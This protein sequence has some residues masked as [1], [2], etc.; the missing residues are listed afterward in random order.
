MRAA[1][2]RVVLAAKVDHAAEAEVAEHKSSKPWHR[3][4][5]EIFEEVAAL[6]VLVGLLSTYFYPDD[7]RATAIWSGAA[8][9]VALALRFVPVLSKTRSTQI[10]L[11]VA[12][13]A[14]LALA[15]YEV[16]VKDPHRLQQQQAVLADQWVAWQQSVRAVASVCDGKK[17]P[18]LEACLA[19][20]LP[21]VLAR[22]PQ[23]EGAL[24]QLADAEF[25]GESLLVNSTI[26]PVLLDRLSIDDR[27]IG[28]GESEPVGAT[29][30]AAA[31]VPE[32]LVANLSDS[33]PW[34]WAWE[35]NLGEFKKNQ[36]MLDRKLIDV[37]LTTPP[38]PHADGKTF[39]DYWSWIERDHL[40]NYQV[41]A[42]VRFVPLDPNNIHGEK[43]RPPAPSG[44]LGKPRATRV[45]MNSLADVK[46]ETLR[47]A[48]EDSGY[49]EAPEDP[50]TRLYVWVYVPQQ[51]GQAVRATWSNVLQN[52]T[53]W[54]QGPACVPK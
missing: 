18:S 41:P 43:G 10:I 33:A 3:K 15:I 35:L 19:A 2:K 26:R 39:A 12:I 6:P 29:W 49:T 1:H 34:V 9:V 44:C 54:I 7:P 16:L 46:D 17:S 45:F 13:P 8:L 38:Q 42:L 48:A 31:R 32:F 22:R 25:A 21:P 11:T 14:I 20:Q 24:G 36:A 47:Q 4:S 5:L 50:N 30:A 52:L 37:L 51:K 23:H 28:T 53:A 27:F 40:N